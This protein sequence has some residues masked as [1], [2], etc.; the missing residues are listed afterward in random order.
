MNEIFQQQKNSYL[1]KISIL[2]YSL[3]KKDK[4]V[5]GEPQTQ[6]QQQKLHTIF[7]CVHKRKI[8]GLLEPTTTTSC[9]VLFR[10]RVCIRSVS[11]IN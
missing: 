1:N 4:K 7:L 5:F 10:A 2:F 8:M 11:P 9:F 6:Q 3:K